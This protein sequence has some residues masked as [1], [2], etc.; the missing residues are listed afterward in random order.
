MNCES[1]SHKIILG[2][3]GGIAA[4]KAAYIASALVK[5][6]MDVH[7]V[8]TE[9]ALKLVGTATFWAITSN[10]VITDLFEP[11]KQREI[12]H[13]SLS[14]SADLMLIAPATADIIGKIANG[15]ADDMLST[16]A[17]VARRIVIC[18]AMNVHMYENPVVQANLDKL[19][20]LGFTIVD[21]ESGRLACGDEGIGRLAEPD[22]IVAV[23]EDLLAADPKDYAGKRVI[24]SAGPT[25]EPIDPVRYISNR[26]S[27]KM[28]Y[29]IAAEAASRGAHVTLV[30]GP[31]ELDYPVGVEVVGVETV[32]QMFDAIMARA[33][34]NDVFISAAAPADFRSVDVRDQKI[35]KTEHLTLELGR[36]EDILAHVGAAKGETIVVGFAAETQDLEANAADKLRRKNADLFVANYVGPGSDVF[37]ADTNEVTLIS[38]TGDKVALPKMSKREVAKAILDYV[39][40]NFLEDTK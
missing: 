14:E 16:M 3:T 1:G 18:P 37:G 39:K 24:V 35:K 36:T 9:H 27:G 10:D 7:V 34:E 28:G 11:P 40:S 2:V 23:V 26:S 31:T 4:Y 38:R 8:M 21:P 13:V 15:I 5:R 12:V 32:R 29:A 30:S 20:G 6:G 19:R 33:A 22:K 25:R 17:M